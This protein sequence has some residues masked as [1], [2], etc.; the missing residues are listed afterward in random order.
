MKDG[1][2]WLACGMEAS[3]E[4]RSQKEVLFSPRFFPVDFVRWLYER[5]R[6]AVSNHALAC[7][8][9]PPAPRRRFAF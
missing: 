1:P 4:A 9:L 6:A 8:I 2:L 3:R 7:E 5:R